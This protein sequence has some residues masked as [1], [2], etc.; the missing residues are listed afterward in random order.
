MSPTERWSFHPLQPEDGD[1]TRQWNDV[2]DFAFLN[3]QKTD[4]IHKLNG[5]KSS[6]YFNTWCTSHMNA[7]DSRTY[8]QVLDILMF[9]ETFLSMSSTSVSFYKTAN[10]KFLGFQ[11]VQL[12]PPFLWDTALCNQ[13]PPFW[14]H[15]VCLKMVG[16]DDTLPCSRRIATS[17][18]KFFFKH[19]FLIIKLFEF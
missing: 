15:Y 11:A 2:L 13:C 3:F 12:K 1:A 17:N 5:T 16:T 10:V 14:D 7:S 9:C 8:R 4:K 6:Y 18:S 19:I